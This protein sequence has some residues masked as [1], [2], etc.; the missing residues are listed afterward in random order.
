MDQKLNL[1]KLIIFKA[2]KN[3]F[4]G[5]TLGVKLAEENKLE[6]TEEQMRAGEAIVGLQAGYNKGASQS[7]QSF[8]QT[9]HM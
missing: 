9:R 1:W 5:P 6:F 7:G 3:G 2:Q 4:N 8:G